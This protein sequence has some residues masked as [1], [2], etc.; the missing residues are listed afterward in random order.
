MDEC[1]RKAQVVVVLPLFLDRRSLR[2]T[3][4]GS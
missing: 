3:N 2:D 4:G 1:S